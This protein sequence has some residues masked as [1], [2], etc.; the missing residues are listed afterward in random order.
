MRVQRIWKVASS[1][2]SGEPRNE[3]ARLFQLPRPIVDILLRRGIDSSDDVGEFL[4]PRLESLT[5]P[6]LLP[7]MAKAV[8][9][10]WAA[11]H[12]NERILV[13]GDYDVDG[14]TSTALMVQVLRG[15]GG[16][17]SCFIPHRIEDG[18]GLSPDALSSLIDTENPDLIVTVDCGTGS[19]ESIK[20][21]RSHGVDV[22][23][24]D[25]HEASGEVADALAVVNP[26][27]GN[28]EELSIL[29]GV[30]VA[31]KLCH[32][33]LKVGRQRN[34]PESVRVD[35]RPYMHVVALGTV[36]DMVPLVGENRVLARYGI[37]VLNM[38]RS[39]G[40]NALADVAGIQQEMTSYH[41][42]FVLGPRINAAGRMGSPMQALDLLLTQD[43]AEARRLA[44]RLEGANRERQSIEQEILEQACSEIDRSYDRNAPSVLVV[45]QRNW[46]SGVVGIVASRLVRRYHRPAVVIAIDENGNG[47]GSC[48]SIEGFDLIK[49]LMCAA[50]Y[51]DQYGG[52]RMAAGLDIPEDRIEEFRGA[53]CARAKEHLNADALLPSQHIDAW[54]ELSD[55]CE[56]FMVAQDRL[57]PFGH[58]NTPPVWAL[59]NVRLVDHRIVGKRH[60]KI[61]FQTPYG[62]Q[63][64]IGF[65]MGDR[66]LPNGPIDLAFQLR[67]NVFR[68]E[69]RLQLMLQD[70]RPSEA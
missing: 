70:F 51:L 24:T 2:D 27:L 56:D 41:I 61:L 42:G 11:I 37:M 50:D 36:A 53:M 20:F 5:D 29:A 35:L 8:E 63:D 31:F 47:R 64:A 10:I 66:E 43:A 67:R 14:V 4:S 44:E 17:A 55:L 18:Y 38:R 22:I 65:G 3:L 54:I 19:V 15:L 49:E 9:R 6:L 48:R 1:P 57:M 59:K 32:A 13:F 21:A 26:K 58:Q 69:E 45:G 33:L 52:H 46:H 68:G 62:M 23:V 25:H 30:G 60:L 16:Q 40:I 39:P 7:D 34:E 28:N 12:A